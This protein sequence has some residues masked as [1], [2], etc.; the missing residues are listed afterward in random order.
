M[1]KKQAWSDSKLGGGSMWDGRNLAM[2]FW[3]WSRLVAAVAARVSPSR[4]EKP[5][6][7]LEVRS[8]V[9]AEKLGSETGLLRESRGR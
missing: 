2:E 1:S 9:R 8:A 7:D 6:S 5:E 3:T 4:C